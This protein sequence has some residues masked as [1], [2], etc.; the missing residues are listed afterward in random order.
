M[1][2]ADLKDSNFTQ[3]SLFAATLAYANLINVN[4]NGTDF[5]QVNLSYSK[6]GLIDELQLNSAISIRGARLSNNS[7]IARDRN[8][9][10]NGHAHG[11]IEEFHLSHSR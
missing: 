11:Q 5:R 6:F 7:A 4:F 1:N 10:K 9:I 2:Y 8:L 3:A